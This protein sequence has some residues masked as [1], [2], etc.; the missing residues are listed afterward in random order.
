M[1]IWPSILF[2][3]A[4]KA[5]ILNQLREVVIWRNGKPVT[6]EAD[7]GWPQEFLDLVGSADEDIPRPP[8]QPITELKDPFE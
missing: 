8:Q 6:V 7:A 1:P 3:M 4:E 2:A 5:K